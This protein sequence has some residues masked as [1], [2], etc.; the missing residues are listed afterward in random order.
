MLGRP[1]QK[2]MDD[3]EK[4]IKEFQ[5]KCWRRRTQYREDWASVVRQVL[6]LRTTIRTLR[7]RNFSIT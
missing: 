7:K 4:D 2:W 5:I 6:V 3:V 1:G